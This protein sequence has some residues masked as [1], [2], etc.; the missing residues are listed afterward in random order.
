MT[1]LYAIEQLVRTEVGKR[2]KPGYLSDSVFELHSYP[3]ACQVFRAL[4]LVLGTCAAMEMLPDISALALLNIDSCKALSAKE[5]VRMHRDFVQRHTDGHGT[6]L[7]ARQ[8]AYLHDAKLAAAVVMGLEDC[9]VALVHEPEYGLFDKHERLSIVAQW[10][11]DM[12]KAPKG[13]LFHT[14]EFRYVYAELL[15]RQLFPEGRDS[16]ARDTA[17]H[18]P[19]PE[20][21]M[22]ELNRQLQ[23]AADDNKAKEPGEA[24]DEQEDGPLGSPEDNGELF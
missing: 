8:L 5:A 23:L 21:C 1:E 12:R 17:C 24:W 4:E 6:G 7:D 13:S 22:E 10:R 15:H 2:N 11:E 19:L 16:R 3:F 14:E 9:L 18:N 20:S